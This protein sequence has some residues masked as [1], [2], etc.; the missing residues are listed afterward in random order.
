MKTTD[1]VKTSK[2]YAYWLRK[3]GLFAISTRRHKTAL[4]TAQT[5]IQD[6]KP[7]TNTLPAKK[8]PQVIYHSHQGQAPEVLFIW[9][10]LSQTQKLTIKEKQIL[11]GIMRGLNLSP[12]KN[13]AF[14]TFE[15]SSKMTPEFGVKEYVR[16]LIS[17][18]SLRL[19]LTFGSISHRSAQITTNPYQQT[20]NTPERLTQK[21]CANLVYLSLPHF[22]EL[23]HFKN[24]RSS[25][26]EAI[27]QA[28]QISLQRPRT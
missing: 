4:E 10:Y 20:K 18:K 24:Y 5:R 26:W 23:S 7:D 8:T 14:F 11:L 13:C 21:S 9:D 1:I 6:S 3:R 15:T 28:N 22:S 25:A 12:D 17:Q 2:Q 19:V 16:P 27:Q